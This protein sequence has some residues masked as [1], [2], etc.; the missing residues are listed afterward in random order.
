MFLLANTI[1]DFLSHDLVILGMVLAAVGLACTF[2]A[3]RIAKMVRN[4]SE[5]QPDDKIMLIFKALGLILIVVALLLMVFAV[6]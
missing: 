5:I 3:K 4:T 1:M 6:N 2:L